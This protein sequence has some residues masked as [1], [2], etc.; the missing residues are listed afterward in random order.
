MIL[1]TPK[2][3][4]IE[5]FAFQRQE[6]KTLSGVPWSHAQ[7]L[8]GRQLV[9]FDENGGVLST[10]DLA[11]TTNVQIVRRE[12]IVDYRV[13]P[14]GANVT[15]LS[16]TAGAEKRADDDY[17]PDDPYDQPDYDY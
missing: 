13:S 12:N 11:L 16:K 4:D 3:P 10:V 6:N 14:D 2:Y 5:P 8:G 1:V 9:T 15:V 17:D 7:I